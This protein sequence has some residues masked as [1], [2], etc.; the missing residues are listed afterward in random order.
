M[1]VVKGVRGE[2]CE[3]C[4]VR[5]EVGMRGGDVMRCEGWGCCEV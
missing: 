1:S 5:C 2:M 3:W 4:V